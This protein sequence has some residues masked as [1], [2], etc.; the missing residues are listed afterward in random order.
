MEQKR[1]NDSLPA[2]ERKQIEKSIDNLCLPCF[3]LSALGALH[4]AGE[5][6]LVSKYMYTILF[7]LLTIIFLLIE[8]FVFK[9]FTIS[10][11]LY[12]K[13]QHSPRL[14]EKE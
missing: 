12:L 8:F 6:F 3:Q 7:N 14:I 11:Q 2:N 5:A 9:K 4:K 13:M 10:F 1:V